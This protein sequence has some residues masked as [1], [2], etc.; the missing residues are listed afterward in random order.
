M[1]SGNLN[2]CGI[3]N[4][5]MCSGPPE[6]AELAAGL[7]GGESCRGPAQSRSVPGNPRRPTTRLYQ[8]PVPAS[9]PQPP[10]QSQLRQPLRLVKPE[11]FLW[12]RWSATWLS[13]LRE[14][15]SVQPGS[16]LLAWASARLGVR[17]GGKSEALLPPEWSFSGFLFRCG[18]E[19]WEVD[20]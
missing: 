12:G 14:G 5:E 16:S 15:K 19:V 2:T 3:T 4:S 1:A 6:V 8:E 18:A 10:V 13:I 17:R 7:L 11:G 9:L 20:S